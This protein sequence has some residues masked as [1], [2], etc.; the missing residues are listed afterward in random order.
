MAMKGTSLAWKL[1]AGVGIE[2]THEAIAAPGLPTWLPRRTDSFSFFLIFLFRRVEN[3]RGRR[4]IEGKRKEKEPGTGVHFAST[5]AVVRS[6]MLSLS[7]STSAN[8]HE[9]R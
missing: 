3:Q 5:G 4:K 9:D 6:E 1:E 8:S 2:P 7:T